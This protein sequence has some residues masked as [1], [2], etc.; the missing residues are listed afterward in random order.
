MK[1]RK[2][3]RTPIEEAVSMIVEETKGPIET[4]LRALADSAGYVLA[5]DVRAVLDQPP[6]TRSPLDGYA[7]RSSDL[8]GAGREHPVCLPVSQY[9]P[10]G[11]ISS[12]RL[13]EGT[14]ARI[15]TGAPLPEGA[16]CV[17][18]QEDTDRGEHR[19]AFYAFIEPRRNVCFKGEDIK[20]GVSGTMT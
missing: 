2:R 19:A 20:A 9:I 11:I 5:G 15:M 10:A 1:T 13:P 14:A 17:I 8:N 4:E 7:L 16:D 3:G 18:P 6:F 12:G